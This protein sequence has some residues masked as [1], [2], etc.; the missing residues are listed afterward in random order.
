ML[1]L[2]SVGQ[3]YQDGRQE[4]VYRRKAWSSRLV[5]FSIRIGYH[6]HDNIHVLS[7][8]IPAFAEKP[9]EKEKFYDTIQQA[10]PEIPSREVCVIL[11]DFN[12]RVGSRSSVDDEWQDVRGPHGYGNLNE[13][14]EELLSFLSINGTV[15]CM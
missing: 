1:L 7:C 13:A 11:G 2:C 12:D 8:Y 6:S 14:G 10:L 9:Q 5:S 4:E 15:L 3:P